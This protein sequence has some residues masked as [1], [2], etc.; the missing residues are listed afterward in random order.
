MRLLYQSPG[1]TSW[2]DAG[3]ENLDLIPIA[4]DPSALIELGFGEGVISGTTVTALDSVP[5]LYALTGDAG[6]SINVTTSSVLTTGTQ[7]VTIAAEDTANNGNSTALV[8]DVNNALRAAGLLIDVGDVEQGI[9]ASTDAG[10]LV[11]TATD[12]T[13]TQ[14]TVTVTSSASGDPGDIANQELGLALGS[15]VADLADFILIDRDGTEHRVIL[16][17]LAETDTVADLFAAISDPH[18]TGTNGKVT[19]GFNATG[20]GLRLTD[21]TATEPDNRPTELTI[22]TVNGSLAA[23]KL[24]LVT[25]PVN[26]FD[27][28][29]T[30]NSAAG[31][32]ARD[33]DYIEGSSIGTKSLVDSFFVRDGA[34]DAAFMAALPGGGVDGDALVGIVGVDVTLSGGFGAV[35]SAELKA[36]GGAA[37]SKVSLKQLQDGAGETDPAKQVVTD[38]VISKLQ[39]LSYEQVIIVDGEFSPGAILTGV[40]DSRAVILSVDDFFES[41]TLTLFNVEGDFVEGDAISDSEGGSGTVSEGGDLAYWDYFGEFDL[42]LAVKA[43]FNTV[44]FGPDIIT[45]KP[46]KNFTL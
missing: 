14:F 37:G 25:N 21:V 23:I 26:P 39:E 46:I 36:P 13:D 40:D 10:R 22:G 20:T 9:R 12:D 33:P 8:A 32:S 30:D 38:P 45:L 31:E 4:A 42:N 17:G 6:I 5:E 19:A 2:I 35:V 43:G 11:L 18:P 29:E 1:T 24:G 41:G 34:F 7:A 27:L 16:N 3:G 15:T 44:G 28:N